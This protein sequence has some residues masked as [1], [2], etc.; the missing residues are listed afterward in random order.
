MKSFSALKY[1]FFFAIVFFQTPKVFSQCFQIESILVDACDTGS[2]EGQNEMVRFKVG[3]TAINTSNLSVNWPNNNWLGLVQNAGTAAK[4]ATLNAGILAAGGCGQLI[5]PTGGVLPANATVLLVTS[6]NFNI[7]LNSFGAITSNIYIIFQNATTNVGHFA[8][9]NATA[10][11]RTLTINFGSCSDTVTYERSSLINTNGTYGGSAALND[12]STVNFNPAGTPTYINNGC[13]APVEIFEVTIGTAPATVCPGATIAL[14]ATAQG[15]TSVSWSAPTGNFSSPGTLNT[16][17]TF[18]AGVTGPVLLTLTATNSCGH[19]KTSVITVNVGAVVTP[20]FNPVGPICSGATL[21]ALPTTSLNGITG[22]WS[23]AINNTTTTIYT[24][25]P[26]PGQCANTTTLTVTVNQPITPTFNAVPPVC[27]GTVVSPLP[28]TSTNGIVGVWTPALNTTATTTYTFTPNAGQCAVTTTLTIV[29]GSNIVPTFNPV[30]PICSG[31]ALS[32]LPTTSI[33]GIAGTWSPALNNTTTTIY[34]FTPNAGQCAISTT[35]TIVVNQNLTPTFAPVAAVCA[36][37]SLTA[38]PTTSINGITGSWSPALNNMVTTTY[39]FTPDAGQCATTATLIITITP[40]LIPAFAAVNPICSGGSLS[41]LPLTSL[42]GIV[43]NWSPALNNTATTTYTFTPNSGQ[44]AATTNLTIVVNAA[45]TVPVFAAVPGICAGGSLSALPSTS[46]NGITGN[47][48]PALNNTATTTYTFTPDAGQCATT[49]TLEIM[50]MNGFDFTVTGKC[51][52]GSFVYQADAVDNS[53]DVTAASYNWQNSNGIS[54]GTDSSSLNV[55]GYLNST[56]E[57]ETFPMTF[58]LTVTTA[59]GCSKTQSFVLENDYCGIQKGISPNG[60]PK[61]EYF[62]L[63]LLG[64]SKLSIFNRYGIKVYSKGA[65][66]NEWHGQSDNGDQ[67]PDGTYYYEIEFSE[68]TEAKTGWIY[69]NSQ[70]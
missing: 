41:A 45:A 66:K 30:A 7:T 15:Q 56:M 33:N 50:V 27:P 63:A 46:T 65:Y 10:G 19:T 51:S 36:G 2:D 20:T 22:T 9:Y 42:N 52:N 37:T 67:L 28:L 17:Y 35:M 48:S 13:V 53:F 59:E 64:V 62:D 25:T 24:F 34:T 21:S 70:Q 1:A 40:A 31:S 49:T 16:N 6:Y 57:T 58:A 32:P 23:P 60:D 18:G 43:G 44:C 4:V 68:R 61:N 55:S 29:V 54:I 8:N 47:W 38:L 3:A 12:G 69:I 11:T 5:E 14:T 39:L 26:T